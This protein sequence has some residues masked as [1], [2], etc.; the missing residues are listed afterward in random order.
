MRSKQRRKRADRGQLSHEMQA[1]LSNQASNGRK[2][3]TERRLL[4]QVNY[5]LY[6]TGNPNRLR[7]PRFSY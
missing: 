4:M 3:E 7:V 5:S 2:N 1:S 6:S